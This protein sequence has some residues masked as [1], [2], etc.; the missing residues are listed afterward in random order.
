[1]KKI[2]DRVTLSILAGGIGFL[3]LIATDMF[4]NRLGISKRSYPTTAAGIWVSSRKQAES[5]QGQLLGIFMTFGLCAIGAMKQIKV[6]SIY[7]KDQLL[8]KGIYFG[9]AFGAIINAGLSGLTN[10]KIKPKDASSNLSYVLSSTIYGII[11]TFAAA[12][13]GDDTLFDASPVNNQISQTGKTTEELRLEKQLQ[14][15]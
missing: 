11:T 6:L 4:S 8:A 1:M 15:G 13:L 10:K 7:G 2:K 3:F 9:A 12:K 14:E 5:W